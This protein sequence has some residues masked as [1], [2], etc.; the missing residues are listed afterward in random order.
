MNNIRVAQV[1]YP[2]TVLGPG[3]RLGIWLQG[4]HVGCRGC[5]SR[6]TWDPEAVVPMSVARLVEECAR[7]VTRRLDGVTI[8]GGEPFEQPEALVELLAG[9]RDAFAERPAVDY[10][11]YS[12]FRLVDLRARFSQVMPLLDAVIPEPYI[13]SRPTEEPWRGSSNQPIVP[14]SPLGRRRYGGKAHAQGRAVQ[15][16]VGSERLAVIG[17]P[18]QDDLARVEQQ[19]ASAGIELGGVSWR[20]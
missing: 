11:C 15:L 13:A 5:M 14:L 6:D 8:S 10:L 9:L 20:P 12:G 4:C 7:I 18:R 2:V 17:I 1:H 3:A 19:L 16:L